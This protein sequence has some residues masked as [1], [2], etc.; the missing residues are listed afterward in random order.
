MQACVAD[1]GQDYASNLCPDAMSQV[2]LGEAYINLNE[3]LVL[4]LM[5]HLEI[6][7]A[8]GH[9]SC[10]AMHKILLSMAGRIPCRRMAACSWL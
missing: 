1:T 5:P 7:E 3:E 6:F 10:N 9:S 8:P 2:H 4:A